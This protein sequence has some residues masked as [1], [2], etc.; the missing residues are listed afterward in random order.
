MKEYTL[1][2]LQVEWDGPFDYQGLSQADW[3]H[4]NGLYQI[5]GTHEVH[6][7]DTLLYVG[8][9]TTQGFEARIRQHEKEWL[10]VQASSAAIYLG[11]ILSE[12]PMGEPELRQAIKDSEQLLIHFCSPPFNSTF[13]GNISV[14]RTL[15]LNFGYRH[16]LPF[17]VSTLYYET[18]YWG[19]KWDWQG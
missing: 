11:R 16:R 4:A 10:T 8:E 2:V 13:Q 17:E 18:G 12:S 9:T 3:Q 15:L 1:R 19:R 5:Y 14:Q 6:G 7:P